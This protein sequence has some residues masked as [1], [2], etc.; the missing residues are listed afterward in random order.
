MEK[1]KIEGIQIV[2]LIMASMWRDDQSSLRTGI[3]SEPYLCV[4]LSLP[5]CVYMPPGCV[6]LF[7]LKTLQLCFSE[8]RLNRTTSA[9]FACFMLLLIIVF[10]TL[11]FPGFGIMK[12]TLKYWLEP[13]SFLDCFQAH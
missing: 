11:T 8:H 7:M 3:G 10:Y 6:F 13:V 4:L 1:R 9:H 5:L 12:F 2:D